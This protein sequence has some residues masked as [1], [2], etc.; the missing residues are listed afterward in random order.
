VLAI[1]S[2]S[3]KKERRLEKEEELRTRS[4]K[5]RGERG[6]ISKIEWWIR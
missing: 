1:D 5:S 4:K 3:K 6:M 2:L